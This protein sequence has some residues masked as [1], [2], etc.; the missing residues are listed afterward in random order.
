MGTYLTK[1]TTFTTGDTVTAASLNNLV[2]NAT[3]TAGSIGS[4]QLGADSVINGKI[5]DSATGAEP[6]TTGT[7][8]DN[9]I[10]NAK[11]AQM[12]AKTVKANATNGTADPTNVPVAVSELL[13]GTA[14]TINAL[15]FTTDL[16]MVDSSDVVKTD[17]TA[18]KIRVAANLIGGKASVTADELDEILIKD[19]TDGAL[20][21][22]TVKTAVQSQVASTVAS[23]ACALATAE[24][25][26]DPSGADANDVVSAATGA[27]MMAKAWVEF[28]STGI[29]VIKINN[30]AG[31]AIGDYTTTGMTVDAL[32]GAEFSGLLSSGQ[33]LSFSGGG[34]FLLS[35]DAVTTAT[36]IYGTLSGAPVV[37]NETVS[38]FTEHLT[39]SFNIT[40]I[41]RTAEGVFDIL[42]A[43]DLPS[44]K[45]IAAITGYNSYHNDILSGN[46]TARTVGVGEGCTVK[47][48]HYNNVTTAPYDPNGV[49]TLIFYGLTS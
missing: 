42:F 48:G 19:V 13:A 2:D 45:Y 22:A 15:S 34:S 21:R 24:E 9:A 28:T 31:Y 30:G 26:I 6:V 27:P 12:A 7:I 29:V 14:T 25:L 10:S 40:S 49:A 47:F 1:G 41:T 44:N 8:R 37:N 38:E 36:K 46:I 4:T 33:I 11:L 5:I 43:T 16:E 23:G 20:K 32:A 35:A 3:V 18:A 39:S 17:S